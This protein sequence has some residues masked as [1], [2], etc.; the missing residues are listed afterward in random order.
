M[1]AGDRNDHFGNAVIEFLQR[2]MPVGG[3]PKKPAHVPQPLH[4]GPPGDVQDIP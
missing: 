3:A 1:V 2:V 4:L